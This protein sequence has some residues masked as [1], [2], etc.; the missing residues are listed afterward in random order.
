MRVLAILLA[1]F[2]SPALAC[3]EATDCKIE[4]G[5]YRIHLPPEAPTGAI[6][7]AHG[8]RG[9][10][11]GT[12]RNEALKS[13]ADDLGVALVAIKSFDEDWTI[14]NAPSA[15]TRP[16]RD[17]TDYVLRVKRDVVD[18]NGIDPARV[19]MVGFSAGGMLTWNVA[20]AAGDAFA[21]FVP[22]S[23]TFWKGPPATCPTD[24]RIYHFHGT[25]DEVVPIS[26]R[27]IGP[28]VQGDMTAVLA[29]YRADRGLGAGRAVDF[30]GLDC[31]E[32]D[33]P[34]TMLR[35]C[36]HPGGHQFRADWIRGVWGEV[37][38][39]G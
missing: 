36:L 39:Q 32:W 38:P 10:A 4:N 33:G 25:S 7:F 12:M 29:M 30:Q 3:G 1:L 23:G 2:A 22:M 5:I 28:T 6:I 37:F 14:P 31:T 15:G 34:A 13:L 26:G 27:P 21:A 8:Y 17:E 18:R 19:L 20:C 16:E 9:T 35:Y 11:E 24:A